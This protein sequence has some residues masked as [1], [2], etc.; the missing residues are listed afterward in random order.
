MGRSRPV[1]EREAL[2]AAYDAARSEGLG[3]RAAIVRVARSFGVGSASV[4]RYL[5]ARRELG[6]LEPRPAQVR[7]PP[8]KLSA[9]DE[10][11]IVGWALATPEESLYQLQQRL[12]RER[13][14]EVSEMTV[15]RALDRAGVKKQRLL[16]EKRAQEGAKPPKV[17]FGP[18]HRRPAI[19]KAT[20]LGYPSDV[21]DGEWSRIEALL[22]A[23]KVPSPRK[24]TLRDVMDALLYQTR[25]GCA[26]RY[27]PRDLPPWQTVMRC[28]IRWQRMGVL[29]RIHNALRGDLRVHAGRAVEPTAGIVDSQSI[30]SSGAREQTGYDGAK[31]V[32][33]RKRHVVVDTLGLIIAVVVHSADIQDRDGGHL[34]VNQQLVEDHPSLKLVYA[35]AGYAGPKF[36]RAVNDALP[37][38]VEVVHRPKASFNG[39]WTTPS[40]SASEAASTGDG[41]DQKKDFQ[42]I[43]KRWIV[44]RT[45]GWLPM[46][47]RLARDYEHTVETAR[48]RIFLAMMHRMAA[49]LEVDRA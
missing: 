47:R 44:E 14:V 16:K 17:R 42:V 15:R 6:T 41:A 8:R 3:Y 48:G 11:A 28:F 5:R 27:L 46:W 25:T 20:R 12:R 23:E 43:R 4:G 30:K 36:E 24:Y 39:Q 19:P 18:Q 31:K 13:K 49:Y 22:L 10:A 35:D 34:V 26:W 38:R 40:S 21:T 1:T 32:S 45:L 29:D 7:P 37:L 9:E 2:V 33:G